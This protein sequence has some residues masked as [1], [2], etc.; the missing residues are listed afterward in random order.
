MTRR[1]ARPAWPGRS[2]AP[3]LVLNEVL[4]DPEM[5]RRLM[6]HGVDEITPSPQPED[7]NR[8]LA[9]ERARWRRVVERAQLRI[10]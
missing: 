3:H 9:E 8:F 10:E 6:E 4:A 1:S 5:R 2:T 7:R